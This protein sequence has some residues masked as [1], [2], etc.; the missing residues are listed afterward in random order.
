MEITIN[1]RNGAQKWVTVL[2]DAA[3]TLD[4]SVPIVCL[5]CG[6]CGT[7]LWLAFYWMRKNTSGGLFDFSHFS[8]KRD[9]NLLK[10]NC[11]S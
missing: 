4:T 7:G 9:T 6:L 8:K 10:N 5:V 1:I 3:H 2:E 11:G